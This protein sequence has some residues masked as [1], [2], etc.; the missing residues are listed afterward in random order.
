[1][2][3]KHKCLMQF[4]NLFHPKTKLQQSF[5]THKKIYKVNLFFYPEIMHPRSGL[6]CT[7][8]GKNIYIFGGKNED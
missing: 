4:I 6:A 8:D 2:I 5:K 1:M 7:T 3:K